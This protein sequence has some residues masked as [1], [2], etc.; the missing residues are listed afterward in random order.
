MVRGKI[1]GDTSETVAIVMAA[2]H[3]S[4]TRVF[5]ESILYRENLPPDWELR[6]PTKTENPSGEWAHIYEI[7]ETSTNRVMNSLSTTLLQLES[8]PPHDPRRFKTVDGLNNLQF[9]N[10]MRANTA[11]RVL[12]TLNPKCVSVEKVCVEGSDLI[13]GI[14]HLIHAS[15]RSP[16]EIL[17]SAMKNFAAESS[18][19]P[20]S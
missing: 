5:I 3:Q 9:T 10:R 16:L 8:L 7:F 17:I 4:P 13:C 20:A 19:I 11:K 18:K 2:D 1:P 6:A 15:G 12:K 14:L